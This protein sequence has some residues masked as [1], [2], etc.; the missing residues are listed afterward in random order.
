MA[1]AFITPSTQAGTIASAVLGIL[2]R[3]IVLPALVNTDW[4]IDF[5]GKIGDTVNVR[6]RALPNSGTARVYTDT[7]RT[8]GTPIVIDD[9]AEGSV[10]VVINTHVYNAVAVTDEQLSLS[11][12][13]F[14]Q[15]V[16]E[17]QTTTVA[18]YME[19]ILGD[20]INA[21]TDA[22]GGAAAQ[23]TGGTL[24]GGVHADILTARTRLSK[25]NVPLDGRVLVVSPDVEQ[26]LLADPEN[27]LI[28]YQDT[29][30]VGTPALRDATVGRLYGMTVVTSNYLTAK[31][32][33]VFNEDAFTFV[34]R[35]PVVPDGATFGQG[36]A[37]AGL[38]MRWLRDYDPAYL[39]DRSVVSSLVGAKEVSPLRRQSILYT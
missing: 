11:I 39:R 7:L 8:A 38:A 33:I 20:V 36:A 22:V 24:A 34:T 37:Y 6:T 5:S 31:S 30:E 29:G 32:A 27:R 28:R 9:I 17:L 2:S 3:K 19:K 13:D 12:V 15:Q 18:L 14:G 10:P 23:I 26:A 25:L 16:L 21:A 4:G 35:A 1:N